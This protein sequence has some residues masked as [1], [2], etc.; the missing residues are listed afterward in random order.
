[1]NDGFSVEVIE[2]GVTRRFVQ[3]C[4]LSVRAALETTGKNHEPY[5]DWT[6]ELMLTTQF[7]TTPPT[8]RCRRCRRFQRRD[9]WGVKSRAISSGV[10]TIFRLN[11][12]SLSF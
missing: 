1:M 2:V 7:C 6:T 4:T 5:F 3:N 8:Y 11:S 10:P 9:Q 12:A